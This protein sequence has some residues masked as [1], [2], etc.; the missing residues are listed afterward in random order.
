M[1]FKID[2]VKNVTKVNEKFVDFKQQT[3]ATSTTSTT[4]DWSM[5]EKHRQE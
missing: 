3:E 2:G 1:V 5:R 4:D